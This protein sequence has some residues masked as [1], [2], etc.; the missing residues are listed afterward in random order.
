MKSL[1][2]KKQAHKCLGSSWKLNLQI[3]ISEGKLRIQLSG[4]LLTIKLKNKFKESNICRS[5]NLNVSIII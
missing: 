1:Y 2:L 4:L 3:K 5:F